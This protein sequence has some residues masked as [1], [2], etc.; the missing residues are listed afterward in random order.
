MGENVQSSLFEIL[1]RVQTDVADVKERQGRM[2]Q[3]LL[4][5]RRVSAALLVMFRGRYD[6]ASSE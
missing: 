3:I 5:H 6:R 2:E 1:K 4:K